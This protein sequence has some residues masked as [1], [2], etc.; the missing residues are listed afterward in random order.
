MN[1]QTSVDAGAKVDDPIA[2][3]GFIKSNGMRFPKDPQIMSP[4]RRKHLRAG[5][6]E[7]KEFNAVTKVVKRDDVVVELGAGMG[8]MSTVCAKLCKAKKVIAVEANPALIPYIHRVHAA[9]KVENV[10]VIN[11]LMGPKKGKPVNFYI[12]EEFVASS[13]S[14]ESPG[15]GP[16]IRV[17]KVPVQNIN[18]LFKAEMPSVLVCD[19]E[20][21]EADLLPKMDLTPLRA[22]VVELHPQWIGQSGV[23]AVFDA[24]HKAGL[25]YFPKLSHAKVCT[26]RKGW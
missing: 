23:Q 6:Y 10:E 21:A 11:A 9:N 18:T 5:T 2:P 13:M 4:K 7:L 25:T 1:A 3:N 12:R 17:D 20:G 16:V 19:I 22:A 8:Y 14:E 24:M 15:A 26:F